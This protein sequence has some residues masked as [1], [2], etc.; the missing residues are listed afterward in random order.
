MPMAIAALLTIANIRGNPYSHQWMNKE[1]VV[2][3]GTL[4]SLKK[5]GNLVICSNTMK[6]E[7]IMP[8]EI[9]QVQ[10]DQPILLFTCGL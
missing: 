4:F 8:S 5:E 6:L 9:N 2:L 3:N 1:N 7:D 10:K